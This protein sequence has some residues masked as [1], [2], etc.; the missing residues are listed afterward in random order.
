MP[1]AKI[2][3]VANLKGGVGKTTTSYALAAA[4]AN[5]HK[6]ALVL[7]LDPGGGTYRSLA[8]NP[9]VGKKTIADVLFGKA[10]MVDAVVQSPMTAPGGGV[11]YTVPFDA[12]LAGI[13]GIGA[14]PL[15]EA[16]RSVVQIMDYIILDTH[17]SHAFLLGPLEVA[18]KIV[19]P[20][21]LGNNDINV[22]AQ[23]IFLIR[24]LSRGLAP[25]SGLLVG[26]VK[27]PMNDEI[28]LAL[29]KLSQLELLL[30]VPAMLDDGREY[31]DPVIMYYGKSWVSALNGGGHSLVNEEDYQLAERV[32]RGVEEYQAPEANWLMFLRLLAGTARK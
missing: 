32:L 12:D 23:T 8:G 27:R 29:S 3:T 10:A 28:K 24:G 13:G 22:S 14:N 21:K 2:I 31:M 30:K 7:D 17:P 15:R 9:V 26:D 1:H 25:L 4:V 16:L 5:R 6:N 20:T 19:I 11:I 18:D